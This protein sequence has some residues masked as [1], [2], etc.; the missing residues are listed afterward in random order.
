MERD[1]SGNQACRRVYLYSNDDD[2][3]D[4]FAAIANDLNCS[5][6]LIRTIY[7][8]CNRS[9]IIPSKLI[10]TNDYH[11]CER[12]IRSIL[13]LTASNNSWTTSV[14]PSLLYYRTFKSS[15]TS[16]SSKNQARIDS[17]D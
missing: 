4:L 10:R 8:H 2:S 9:C 14:S 3:N 13:A 7:Q 1:D 6:R 15:D 5:D 12:F 17:N 16:Y 11:C